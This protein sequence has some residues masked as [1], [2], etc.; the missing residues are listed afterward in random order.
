MREL[1][2]RLSA[3]TAY[4]PLAGTEFTPELITER[5]ALLAEDGETVIGAVYANIDNDQVGFV[6]GL[7]VRPSLNTY[8]FPS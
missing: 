6:F 3:E 1:W 2:E 4:D 7:Y 5:L 8:V